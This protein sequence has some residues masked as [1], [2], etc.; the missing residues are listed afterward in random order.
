[1][2]GQQDRT[3]CIGPVR[4][5]T[6]DNS[7]PIACANCA[8]TLVTL[9]AVLFNQ[10]TFSA[11]VPQRLMYSHTRGVLTDLQNTHI[12]LCK[13]IAVTIKDLCFMGSSTKVYIRRF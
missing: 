5:E 13:I 11:F 6:D 4:E 12:L 1:M 8:N 7:V 9:S 2:C 3:G 10:T